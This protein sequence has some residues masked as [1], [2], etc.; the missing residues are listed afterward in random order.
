MTRN[1]RMY[2][3][4]PNM[5]RWGTVNYAIQASWE[6]G[7]CEKEGQVDAESNRRVR[8][9]CEKDDSHPKES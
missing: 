1:R 7:I 9:W 8:R 4:Y 6:Q 3:N 5:I 2:P